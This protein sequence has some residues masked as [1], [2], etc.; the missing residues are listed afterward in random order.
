MSKTRS[1]ALLS[2][3]PS[4]FIV[5]C[6]TL[7][8]LLL[9]MSLWFGLLKPTWLHT[10]QSYQQAHRLQLQAHQIDA[11]ILQLPHLRQFMH[12]AGLLAPM[13]ALPDRITATALTHAVFIRALLQVD[14]HHWQAQCLGTYRQLAA[15]THDLSQQPSDWAIQ[16][17][18]WQQAAKDEPLSL[19]LVWTNTSIL[20]PKAHY[21]WV[22]KTP[23]LERD[24]FTANTDTITPLTRY[25]LAQ[26]QW[27]GLLRDSSHSAAIIRLPNQDIRLV[28]LGDILGTEY[29]RLRQLHP[30]YAEFTD[31]HQH[32][33]RLMINFQTNSP[34]ELN[35]G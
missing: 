16:S 13:K 25:P 28:V 31:P 35:H 30:H 15:F 3:L 10:K 24:P 34:L 19:N 6:L 23:P 26:L 14:S 5:L 32:L 4:K 20:I 8:A 2:I 17:Q 9:M 27:L 12:Q 29:W 21:C 7:C 33:Q 1:S 18:Q 11:A 22:S